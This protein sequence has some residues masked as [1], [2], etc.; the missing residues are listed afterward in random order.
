[1]KKYLFLF[2][3]IPC[4]AFSQKDTV[5]SGMYAWRTPTEQVRKNIRSK[6]LFSGKVADMDY[7]QMTAN[8]LLPSS[9][10]ITMQVPEN[11][12]QLLIVKGGKLQIAFADSSWTI[13]A[14]SIALLLPGE[15]YSLQNSGM[16][17]GSY[18]LAG[19]H[20]RQPVD[21]DRGKIAGGSM[22]KDWNQIQFKPHDKGGIRNFLE[23]PT[24]MCK[25]LEIHVTTLK[26]GIKSHEPHTHKAEEIVLMLHNKT[27]MQIG[28]QFYKGADGTI[29][30][31]GSMVPHA[32]RNDGVGDC[33]Y[34]AI[35]FE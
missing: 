16:D 29:Y 12:E 13:G 18:Y 6:V 28:E 33:I 1:M 21:R 35:Q 2:L 20:S 3:L 4:L 22:A 30:Y 14:G 23:R 11:E 17:T 24:A 34:F 9:E 27:E 19:Y 26:Q 5:L 25:R 32:I 31:L 7:L 10:K 15:K 8:E